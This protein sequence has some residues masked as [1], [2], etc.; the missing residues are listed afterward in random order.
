MKSFSFLATAFMSI[1]AFATSSN[2]Y[3]G[4][5]FNQVLGVI[6]NPSPQVKSEKQARELEV[7]QSG[8][9]PVYQMKVFDLFETRPDLS[10]DAK[11]TTSEKFDYYD[12]LPKKLHPNGVCITGEWEITQNNDYSGYFKKGTKGLFIGR[13]SVTKER[14]L[15]TERRGFGFAGKIFPT[16]DP[17]E[18]VKTANFFTVDV[19]LG[20]NIKRFLE[21][22]LTNEPEIGFELSALGMAVKIKSALETADNNSSFRPITPIAKL[23][24]TGRIKSPQWIRIA[25]A[26]WLKKNDQA[27]FRNEILQASAENRDL[28]FNIDVSDESKDREGDLWQNIGHITAKKS[29]VSFGC[30]R[31]LHFAHPKLVD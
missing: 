9:M 29:M 25:P 30:D 24:E 4:S 11:R 1:S 13:I 3:V 19:V 21:T 28:I 8:R 2:D 17:N 31:Q 23:Q 16:L 27:D 18:V 10:Q 12:Y 22:R 20:H 5:S 7:Y 26:S 6:S 15:K 14:V